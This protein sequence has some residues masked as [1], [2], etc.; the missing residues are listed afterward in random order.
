[1][2]ARKQS[3]KVVVLCFLILG[4]PVVSAWSQ[5]PAGS[6]ESFRVVAM[7]EKR[8]LEDAVV[9]YDA[10]I[11]EIG[12]EALEVKK[13]LDWVDL[14]IERVRDRTDAVPSELLQRQRT[15]QARRDQ[16][17]QEKSRLVTMIK[18]HLDRLTALDGEVRNA[19][20]GKP[21][22]WWSFRQR[23]A[24]MMNMGEAGST[25]FGQSELM[26]RVSKT[27]E[28]KSLDPWTSMK[29]TDQ[30]LL[31]KFSRP[32]LFDSGKTEVP[33]N[34]HLFLKK[35]AEV[36]SAYS[37]RIQLVGSADSRPIKTS[38]YPSNWELAAGRATNAARILASFG[39]PES[40]ISATSKGEYGAPEANDSKWSMAQ[41][42]RVDVSV[43]IPE[44]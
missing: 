34:D 9:D 32:I 8:I 13:D 27:L 29:S 35:V 22:D 37:G 18:G 7:D 20:A 43:L 39:V 1:M 44:K 21:L 33:Q 30:G 3:L 31:V 14:Q 28:D 4:L 19:F 38:K 5:S 24:D 15:L 36:A 10:R 40:D 12:K 17:A 11:L 41:N 6:L 23:V 2:Y 16:L 26:K 25:E 42:R